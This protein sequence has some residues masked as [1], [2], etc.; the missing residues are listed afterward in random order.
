MTKAELIAK[1]S[2]HP[3]SPYERGALEGMNS[4]SQSEAIICIGS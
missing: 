4:L 1:I 2:K 3:L